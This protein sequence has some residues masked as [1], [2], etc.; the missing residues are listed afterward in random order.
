M[1][2]AI[3]AAALAAALAG[4]ATA[5]NADTID[6]SQWGGDSTALATTQ[7]GV[8]VGGVAFSITAPG[9]G[10]T[11]LTQDSSWV[12]AFK[13]NAPVYFDNGAPGPVSILFQGHVNSIT[14]I[15]VQANLYGPYSATLTAYDGATVLGAETVNGLSQFAP[16]T[17][18]SFG[19]ASASPITQIVI[20][21]TNDS[22]GIGLSTTAV[23]ELSTWAMMLAGLAGLGFHGY[24]RNKAASVAA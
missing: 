15:A 17:A 24:R 4:A 11:I 9:N 19:F 23:P 10:A 16:N 20:S 6:W 22:Q 1:K 3:F 8:T 5:A 2:S 21:A 18:P 7:A 13:D 12:G 14:D